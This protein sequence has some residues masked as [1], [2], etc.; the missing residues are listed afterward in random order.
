MTRKA[1]LRTATSTAVLTALAFGLTACTTV[2]ESDKVDYKTA[3]KA[4]SLEVPPDLTQLQKD[5]RYA[6]PE[7][8]GVATASGYQ[9]Q[10]DAGAPV[11]GPTG[12]PVASGDAIGPVATDAV[13]IERAGTTRWLVVKQT[14]EQLWPQLQQFWHDSGFTLETENA[15]TGIMETNWAEN[16]AKIPQDIIRRTLGRV[17]DS[18]YSTNTKDKYRTRLE[19]RP[20]GSTEV[21]ISERGVEEVPTGPQKEG[22]AWVTRPSDPEL[23]AEFLSRLMVRL[24]GAKLNDARTVVASANG[25]AAATTTPSAP[26]SAQ[27][28]TLESSKV[29]VEGFDRAWR[30][31]GLALDRAGFTVE[32]RDRVQGIYFVRYVDPD[33]IKEEGFFSKLFSTADK[34]KQAQRYRVT[35]AS[36]QGATSSDVTVATDDG[37]PD[38]TPVSGKILKVLADELK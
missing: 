35:V 11:G 36:S 32:D 9:Q 31:V 6:I 4:P 26:V 33:S 12:T 30:R 29:V 28:A 15:Q 34:F 2:F 22:T 16:R 18:A 8:R 10:R 23:E 3:T 17:F 27:H 19:R 21:Y 13:H 14:P 24:T 5:N 38:T 1:H 25:A 37:K 7:G 20:D